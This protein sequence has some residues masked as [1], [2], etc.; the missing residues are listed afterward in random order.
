MKRK[1]FSFL[2]VLILLFSSLSFTVCAKDYPKED[3]LSSEQIAVINA[4]N[5]FTVYRKDADTKVATGT[6]TKIMTALLALEY[7]EGRLQTPVTV[8]QAALRGLEGSAV[9]NL[10]AGENIPALDLIHAVLV[11][12]M[13]DA[14]NTLALAVGGTMMNFV[15]MMNQKA[16]EIG[17]YDTMYLNATG[18]TSSAHTTA[19]DLAQLAYYAY[20]N[21]IF[22]EISSKRFYQVAAT[23]KNPAVMIYARNPLI[24]TQSEYYYSYAKGMSAG[25]SD[26]DGAQIISAVSYG[27][28]PYICVA[29]GSKKDAGGKIGGYSDVKNL[30]AWASYNFAERK[31][32]DKSKIICELSVKA[33]DGVSHVLVV[34]EKAVYAFLDVDADLSAVTLSEQLYHK[35]L[36]APVAKGEVV[37]SVTLVLN[38]EPIGYVDLIAKNSVKRSASGGFLLG[39]LAII[40][41]PV[42]IIAVLLALGFLLFPFFKRYYLMFIKPKRAENFRKNK[43][44]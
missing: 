15:K 7:F 8:S 26:E 14:A 11:A 2:L 43:K 23:D 44:R 21:P 9:L 40:T 28:D 13:N 19:N 31:I 27:N 5:G 36:T 42:F 22:M 3:S 16:V 12:G 34:P 6:S 38:G 41:H 29:I 37:G 24:T 10:K 39:I 18:L 20:R 33:G 25:Y 17:M 1:F 30:L 35:S 32:L 4:N